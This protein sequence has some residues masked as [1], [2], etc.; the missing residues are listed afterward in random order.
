MFDSLDI[1]F[2]FRCF[3]CHCISLFIVLLVYCVC[4]FLF[5]LFLFVCLFGLGQEHRHGTHCLSKK[6]LAEGQLQIDKRSTRLQE[7]AEATRH[8]WDDKPSSDKS[9]DMNSLYIYM[10]L[11]WEWCGSTD[12]SI[13]LSVP[14]PTQKTREAA[15]SKSKM[16]LQDP[17]DDKPN[18]DKNTDMERT[19][20]WNALFYKRGMRLQDTR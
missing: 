12:L 7:K 16:R 3:Q 10:G 8:A 2:I 18:S 6:E 11:S 9:T 17:W 15:D 4:V 20:T 19:A 1:L 5:S 13:Y 14:V